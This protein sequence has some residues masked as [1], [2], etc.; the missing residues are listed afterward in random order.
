MPAIFRS[1]SFETFTPLGLFALGSW[2]KRALAF[3]S[4]L[5]MDRGIRDREGG[6]RCQ[7]SLQDPAQG[8]DRAR[9]D[10]PECE[11]D[12]SGSKDAALG[13]SDLERIIGPLRSSQ[14]YFA[15]T[16]RNP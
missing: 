14:D 15:I 3:L 16:S 7:A 4:E 8:F 6:R 13:P 1:G 10:R 12:R 11:T 9:G 5:G 2:V